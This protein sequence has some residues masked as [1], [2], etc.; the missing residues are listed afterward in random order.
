MDT[1]NIIHLI[2]KSK[3]DNVEDRII[4]MLQIIKGAYSLIIQTNS[5]LIAIRDEY[6]VRPLSLGKLKKGGWVVASETCSFEILE[7][8]FVRDIKAGE[9]VILEKDKEII[10]KE[11]FISK[12]RPCAFEYIYFSRPDSIIDGK[13][14]I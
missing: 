11:I 8:E 1:E 12:Y 14:S 7:A 6:G 3:K 13:N 10:S 9:M 4:E 2:A 5:K